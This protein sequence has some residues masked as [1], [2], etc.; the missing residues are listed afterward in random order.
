MSSKLR[1]K[2]S[3]EFVDIQGKKHE[4][5]IDLDDVFS[6]D[7]HEAG[8]GKVVEFSVYKVK[9]PLRLCLGFENNEI[10]EKMKKDLLVE[11]EV[12]NVATD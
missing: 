5:V 2:Y 1:G 6:V 8:Y 7:F 3:V 12:K 9:D 10:W 4:V 11:K